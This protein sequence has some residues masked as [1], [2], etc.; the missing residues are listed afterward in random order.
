[1]QFPSYLCLKDFAWNMHWIYEEKCQRSNFLYY[2]MLS[3]FRLSGFHLCGIYLGFIHLCG[4]YLGFIHLCGIH[5]GFIHLCGIHLCGFHLCGI[6]LLGF[7]LWDSSLLPSFV[8]D[9]CCQIIPNTEEEFLEMI[10]LILLNTGFKIY[11]N[12]QFN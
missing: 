3:F 2:F 7:I 8:L 4:I 1:M 10:Y 9:F 12:F 6:H 5:L 11:G